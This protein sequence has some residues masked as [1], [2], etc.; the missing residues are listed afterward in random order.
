MAIGRTNVGGGSG[1]G[2]MNFRV[3]GA[4]SQPS[5]PKENDIW[6]KT[7][8]PILNGQVFFNESVDS[9]WTGGGN[10]SVLITYTA[11]S[12]SLASTTGLNLIVQKGIYREVNANL[13]GC[14]QLIGGTWTSMDAYIYHASSGWVQFSSNIYWIFKE[15]SSWQN[16]A[17]FTGAA[18]A[19]NSS[20]TTNKQAPGAS[21]VGNAIQ[22][23][24]ANQKNGVFMCTHTLPT[25]RFRTIHV[26]MTTTNLGSGAN[27]GFFVWN[28]NGTYFLE[29]VVARTTN[30]SGNLTLDIS[31]VNSDYYVGF[32]LYSQATIVMYNIWMD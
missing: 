14:R 6:I 16:G 8:T 23:T 11:S 32:G 19:A 3:I 15:G 30:A 13:T 18:K 5:S 27:T 29:N 12:S 17:E 2:G 26:N 25:S 4:S 21:W 28:Q 20:Q 10:G 24:Q 9:F 7:S 31:N 1:T 22:L